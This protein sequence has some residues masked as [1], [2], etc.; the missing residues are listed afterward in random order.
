MT[1]EMTFLLVGNK[2]VNK[3]NLIETFLKSKRL[4]NSKSTSNSGFAKINIQNRN[5]ELYMQTV[6]S[7]LDTYGNMTPSAFLFV[8]NKNNPSTFKDLG[9][10]LE[11][12]KKVFPSI[13][14]KAKK[15][16]VGINLDRNNDGDETIV[17][18][19]EIEDFARKTNAKSYQVNYDDVKNI[20]NLFI[21]IAKDVL[22]IYGEDNTQDSQQTKMESSESDISC[23]VT[24]I[25]IG[26]QEVEKMNIINTFIDSN[27]NSRGNFGSKIVQIQGKTVQLNLHDSNLMMLEKIPFKPSAV[28]FVYNIDKKTTFDVLKDY[29]T[30]VSELYPRA[31][32]V[33]VGNNSHLYESEEVNENEAREFAQ[34][35]NAT[36]YLT[37]TKDKTNLNEI[38]INTAK[39]I[40]NNSGENIKS[41]KKQIFKSNMNQVNELGISEKEAEKKDGKCCCLI[42]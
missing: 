7:R 18:Y 27:G 25:L 15:I 22:G 17:T 6:S 28:L 39:S 23:E 31:V 35:I 26:E 37:N 30:K 3:M 21:E 20:E 14:P 36:F 5:I 11:E 2:D 16:L 40:I 9:K 34:K 13:F 10:L 1:D 29:N 32:K 33:L 12:V 8:Y 42:I 38:F 19:N 4:S 41:E 24:M